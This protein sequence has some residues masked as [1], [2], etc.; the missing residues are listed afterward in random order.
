MADST[1]LSAFTGG[2]LSDWPHVEQS[3]RCILTTPI[4]S[5]VMRRTFGSDVPDLVDRKMTQANVLKVYSAAAR[6]ILNWEPRF[7]MSYARLVDANASGLVQLEIFGTYFPR[8]HLG[9][10]SIAENAST[11]IVYEGAT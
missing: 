10:Y 7:R 5:R 8:G 2:A 1:G 9:D 3:I 6:A 4:G 11:R